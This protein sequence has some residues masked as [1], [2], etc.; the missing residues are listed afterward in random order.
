LL[1]A[2]LQGTELLA[3]DATASHKSLKPLL[4]ATRDGECLGIETG[5]LHRVAVSRPTR[6]KA[7]EHAEHMVGDG[8]TLL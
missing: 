4:L 7:K 2:E 3:H 6:D 8:E 1:F 5:L